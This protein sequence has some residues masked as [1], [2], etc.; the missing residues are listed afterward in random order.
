M[1]STIRATTA[2]WVVFAAV[3]LMGLAPLWAE[4]PTGTSGGTK[5]QPCSPTGKGEGVVNVPSMPEPNEVQRGDFGANG[6]RV[7][8]TMTL[9]SEGVVLQLPTE[10]PTVVATYEYNGIPVTTTLQDRFLHFD[11]ASLEALRTEKLE[12]VDIVLA[13]AENQYVRARLELPP[14]TDT[15]TVRIE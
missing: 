5:N 15:V 10:V 1:T 2:T 6:C 8:T 13:V 4:E 12:C 9:S 14:G 7:V 11:A 3:I